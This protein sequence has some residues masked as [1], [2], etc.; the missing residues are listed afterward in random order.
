MKIDSNL[1]VTNDNMDDE[2]DSKIFPQRLMVILADELNQDAICWLPHGRSFIIRNR[3]LFAENVMPKYFSRKAK[4]SSFTR[5]LNR[6]NFI[7]VASGSEL[8]AYHHEFFLR[9]K[10]HL[11]AQMFCKNA[12]T[13][14]AMSSPVA[15]NVSNENSQVTAEVESSSLMRKD[16]KSSVLTSKR[17]EQ[18]SMQKPQQLLVPISE[19]PQQPVLNKMNQRSN[20]AMQMPKKDNPLMSMGPAFGG[21][22]SLQLLERQMQ[23]I[24]QEQANRLFMTMHLGQRPQ[25]S[26]GV[27][28]VGN[29]QMQS[30]Q[31][32]EMRLMQLRQLLELGRRQQ[33]VRQP[34][35]NRASA[36]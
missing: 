28:S 26:G 15:M 6:W 36:A 25:N 8:G 20:F 4:Y 27:H 9:D 21:A 19:K 1:S 24:Q 7:R 31:Q 23:M 34:S 16:D 12:R 17:M 11:A 30:I 18:V 5:K 32:Q 33:Q 14:L 35:S 3:K 29:S 22:S 13:M 2:D 10:P